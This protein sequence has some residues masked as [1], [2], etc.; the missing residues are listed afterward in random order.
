MSCLGKDCLHTKCAIGRNE[1]MLNVL[2][3]VP[4]VM[5]KTFSVVW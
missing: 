2:V 4:S 1:A 3:L 5:D